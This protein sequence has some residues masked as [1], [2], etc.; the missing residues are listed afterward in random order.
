[1]VFDKPPCNNREVPLYFLR[2]LRAKFILGR[3][4]NYFD[5]G[6][7]QGVDRGYAHDR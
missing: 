6:D 5:I 3:P 7:F 2:K 1:M 4:V